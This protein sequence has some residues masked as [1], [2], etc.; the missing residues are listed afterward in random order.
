M[1]EN[2]LGKEWNV[3]CCRKNT[4]AIPWHVCNT[5]HIVFEPLDAWV[6]LLLVFATATYFLYQTLS[7]KL[8][9]RIMFTTIL[10]L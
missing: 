7:L 9:L 5:T 1:K 4:K 8:S 2:V 10:L 3:T 6:Q